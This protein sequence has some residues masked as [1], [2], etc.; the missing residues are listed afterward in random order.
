[1]FLRYN[2]SDCLVLE[3]NQQF[4]GYVHVTLHQQGIQKLHCTIESGV[5]NEPI[6]TMNKIQKDNTTNIER[7][8]IVQCNLLVVRVNP[9]ITIERYEH[10][11]FPLAYRTM[12]RGYIAIS[13]YFVECFLEQHCE[14]HHSSKSTDLSYL[15][16]IS[17]PF[18][19]SNIISQ[20]VIVVKQYFYFFQTKS[21]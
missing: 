16:I 20:H 2:V 8:C 14:Q 18:V 9:D 3:L 6:Q 10:P 1:M 4:T 13:A 19:Y 5:K 12:Y 21:L 15:N 11:R 17:S 7:R